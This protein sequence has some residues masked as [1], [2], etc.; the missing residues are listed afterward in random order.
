VI[1]CGRLG[2]ALAL[3]ASIGW[4]CSA[5]MPASAQ[6]RSKAR[7]K[8]NPSAAPLAAS[9]PIGAH[10]ADRVKLVW[11]ADAGG[12]GRAVAVHRGLA[13]V[14]VAAGS[15]LSV[16]DLR[17]G[18]RSATLPACR[19]VVR[20]GLSFSG[21]KLVV[22]CEAAL[23]LYDAAKLTRLPA[24]KLASAAVTAVAIVG[25]RV[26][27]G[28]RDGVVRVYAFDGAPTVQ[29]AVPGPPIDVKSLD[30]TR[31]GRRI[32]VAW[33]QGSIWWWDTANPAEPHELV[34]HDNESDT[35]AFSDDGALLAEEGRNN[36]TTLWSVATKPVEKASLR[37][38]AWIKRLRF[39]RDGRWLVRG[40]SDGLE[41]AEIAGPRRVALDSRGAV[42]D[43]AFDENA[44]TLAA[45]DRDGRLTVWAAR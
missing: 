13:R 24:P 40:G 34:R 44:S 31:D 32:A 5:S 45:A 7:S 26:A 17:S 2:L 8:P 16:Y 3:S 15:A 23:E 36:F 1:P 27:V 30:L 4:A 25:A 14:V 20:G 42:E 19:E 39:T 37:N 11:E 41:L 9:G 43:V 12:A 21:S 35:L 6:T 29:I 18:K 28:H 38:G 10:N 33:V 22:V